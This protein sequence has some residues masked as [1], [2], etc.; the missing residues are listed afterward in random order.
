M[1]TRVNNWMGD[2]A[3]LRSLT[4]YTAAIS[5][6]A[7]F[8]FISCSEIQSVQD[9]RLFQRENTAKPSGPQVYPEDHEFVFLPY[10]TVYAKVDSSYWSDLLEN[11]A[12]PAAHFL[13]IWL[14]FTNI[15]NSP[16]TFD[17]YHVGATF[18][19]IT[20][21]GVNYHFEGN[22]TGRLF[23]SALNPRVPGRFRVVFDV[24]KGSYILIVGR[25][26]YNSMSYRTN[27]YDE[28]EVC[29]LRLKPRAS[30]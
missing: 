4:R 11:G 19:L 27:Y 22:L 25:D 20:E 18:G 8:A 17:Q 1:V 6:L 21:S 13:V 15:G 23:E 7:A 12:T 26:V 29:R 14:T 5:V 28:T 3:M 16:V 2:N 24:P 9:S 10:P 30:G